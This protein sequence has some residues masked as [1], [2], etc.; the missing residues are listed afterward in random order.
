VFDHQ[1]L[2]EDKANI[3]LRVTENVVEGEKVEGKYNK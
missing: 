1:N 3:K 2:E